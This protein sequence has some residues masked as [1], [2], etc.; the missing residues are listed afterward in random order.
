MQTIVGKRSKYQLDVI[1]DTVPEASFD[2]E[3]SAVIF[4]YGAD[5]TVEKLREARKGV[6]GTGPSNAIG[7]IVKAIVNKADTV[8]VVMAEGE[9]APAKPAKVAKPKREKKP[10]KTT[11]DGLCLCGCGEKVTREFLP[12]HDARYKGQLVK[13][14]LGLEST[15]KG[16]ADDA[17]VIIDDRNWSAFVEKSRHALAAKVERKS[18]SPST[19][20]KNKAVGGP[21]VKLA[22]M[23]QAAAMLKQINRY[24]DKA[25]DRQIELS[26][27]AIPQVIDGSHPDLTDEEK[28]ELGFASAE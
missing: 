17:L 5:E 8:R 16:S 28:V 12:G 4:P 18:K 11:A 10:V 20:K 19:I 26:P 14:A 21:T 27:E 15:F 7:A 3:T 23:K 25:G 2:L 9:E 6:K 22:E 24:G 1:K 13:A